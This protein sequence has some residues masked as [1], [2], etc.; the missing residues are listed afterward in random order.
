MGGETKKSSLKNTIC[1]QLF[2]TSHFSLLTSGTG[3]DILVNRPLHSIAV[4]LPFFTH[5]DAG[6]DHHTPL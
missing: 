5:V 4:A 6:N 1:E 3:C 2:L